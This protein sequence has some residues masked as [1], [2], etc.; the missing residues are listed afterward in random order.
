MTHP[1][2]RHAHRSDL[3]SSGFLLVERTTLIKRYN[4][5]LSQLGIQETELKKFRIDAWGWSP[6]VAE[7]LGDE[8]YLGQSGPANPYAI[9]ISP[10]QEYCKVQF[11]FYS[12]DQDLIKAVFSTY[13]NQIADITTEQGICMY[14]DQ[15]IARFRNPL[16]LLLVDHVTANFMASGKIIHAAQEQRKLLHELYNDD[17]AWDDVRNY[18]K[19]AT[20]AKQHGDLRYRS[21]EMDSMPYNK[22]DCLYTKAFEGMFVFRSLPSK[23]PLL[24]FEQSRKEEVAYPSSINVVSLQEPEEVIKWLK[25]EELIAFDRMHRQQIAE[26]L[27]KHL[28]GLFAKAH[29]QSYPEEP[30]PDRTEP[31]AKIFVNRMITLGVLTENYPDLERLMLLLERDM[32]QKE[33]DVDEGLRKYIY[34]P[35]VFLRPELKALV[36]LLLAKLNPENFLELFSYDEEAFYEQFVDWPESLQKWA[37]QQLLKTD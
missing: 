6:D 20:S 14:T 35:Y 26:R 32:V 27:K 31:G 37:E 24:I 13:R 16:D 25:Q 21:L 1:V 28:N 29:A 19:L 10:E 15:Q 17:S 30:I 5:C 9:I 2:K 33:S 36:E 7:E 8:F 12:F 34:T 22:V 18:E 11:P 3:F 4:A 23:K